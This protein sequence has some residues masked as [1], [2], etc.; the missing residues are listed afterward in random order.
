MI[1]LDPT[2]RILTPRDQLVNE[3]CEAASV[4][5]GKT[6]DRSVFAN[7]THR[8]A[9]QRQFVMLWL[10]WKHAGRFSG[11]RVS[12]MLGINHST[13]LSARKTAADRFPGAPFLEPELEAA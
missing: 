11:L 10:C 8:D 9:P 7:R 1:H 13:I 6:V 5:F 3:A 2:A 4:Y 12:K